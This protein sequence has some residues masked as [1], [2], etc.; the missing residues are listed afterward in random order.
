[1]LEGLKELEA[2]LNDNAE[3]SS[4]ELVSALTVAEREL[5]KIGLIPFLVGEIRQISEQHKPT[6]DHDLR[7][8]AGRLSE[9]CNGQW[10]LESIRSQYEVKLAEAKERQATA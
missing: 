7:I 2:L 10:K 5:D 4:V 9:A 3:P 8:A 6:H 1:M